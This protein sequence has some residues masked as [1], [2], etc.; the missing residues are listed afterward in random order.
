MNRSNDRITSSA[1]VSR[2]RMLHKHRHWP[3]QAMAVLSASHGRGRR[4]AA[5]VC[6]QSAPDNY[7]QIIGTGS[8]MLGD[9]G[10]VRTPGQCRGGHL[11][12]K[13]TGTAAD[14]AQ[15]EQDGISRPQ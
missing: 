9:I 12:D 11:V 1:L 10:A 4:R 5:Q 8:Q 14:L 13:N 3:K 15:I 2:V 6:G 7:L